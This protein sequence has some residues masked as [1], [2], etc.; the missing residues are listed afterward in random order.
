VLDSNY[1]PKDFICTGCSKLLG[2]E[3][4]ERNGW[5]WCLSCAEDWGKKIKKP[6]TE[7]EKQAEEARQKNLE[8]MREQEAKLR[9]LPPIIGTIDVDGTGGFVVDPVT[10]KKKPS[11]FAAKRPTA[12]E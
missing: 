8:R 12:Q 4:T 2:D 9:A 7:Q 11:N 10:G 1:H 6:Q 3:F 5:P